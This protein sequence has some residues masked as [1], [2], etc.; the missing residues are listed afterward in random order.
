MYLSHFLPTK[1]KLVV[2]IL[3]NINISTWLKITLLVRRYNIV[4]INCYGNGEFFL[5]RLHHACTCIMMLRS[6]GIRLIQKL[7]SWMIVLSIIFVTLLILSNFCVCS[8]LLQLYW[9]NAYML[10][11]G[12]L[13]L[14]NVFFHLTSLKAIHVF[15]KENKDTQ[16]N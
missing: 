11:N 5:G 15:L 3:Q 2:W 9:E 7:Q 13:G 4:L 14:S 12:L 10:S 6:V 8:E 1:V 16:I